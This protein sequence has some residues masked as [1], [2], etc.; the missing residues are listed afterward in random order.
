[1][2]THRTALIGGPQ[3]FDKLR[4]RGGTGASVANPAADG[5]ACNRLT[6]RK[7]QQEFLSSVQ[8][9]TLGYNLDYLGSTLRVKRGQIARLTVGNE[10]DDPITA[11]WHDAYVP[12]NIDGGPQSA[13]GKGDSWDAE[14]EISQPATTLWYH[15][16][17]HG[18]PGS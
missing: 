12:G 9:P 8:T 16:H 6:G 3:T 15:S 17:V 18:Q 7:S 10:T 4:I 2:I 13:F 14:L 5:G 1:M 11:H